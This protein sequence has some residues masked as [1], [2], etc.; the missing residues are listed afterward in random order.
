MAFT[1]VHGDDRSD[2]AR[3]EAEPGERLDDFLLLVGQ[4]G[5][6]GGEA[7]AALR[8]ATNERSVHASRKRRG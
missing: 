7:D 5:D 8:A 3:V 4:V 1:E 2:L 6:V